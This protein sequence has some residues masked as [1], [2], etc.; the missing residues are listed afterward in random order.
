MS[1]RPAEEPHAVESGDDPPTAVSDQIPTPETVADT[2]AT[3]VTSDTS[4]HGQA[5]ASLSAPRDQ[6]AAT[7]AEPV[8][9]GSP[10]PH[11]PASEPAIFQPSES[12]STPEAE[13]PLEA[14]T[15]A[16]DAQVE[17]RRP[18]RPRPPQPS[19]TSPRPADTLFRDAPGD[20]SPSSWIARLAE[21]VR[22]A[23][24]TE[25]NR[26]GSAPVEPTPRPDGVREPSEPTS[27]PSETT[28]RFLAPR[29]GI[30]PA[31]VRVRRGAQ[32]SALASSHQADAVASGA[33]VVIAAGFPEDTPEGLGL[34]AH[35]LTHVARARQARFV[36]PITAQ[37]R[38]RPQTIQP[39]TIG[40]EE[41]MATTVEHLVRREA[42][43]IGAVAPFRQGR[44]VSD[45][46]DLTS[47]RNSESVAPLRHET[48]PT[49]QA[50]HGE[51]QD[52]W[53]GLP[54]PWEPMPS[55]LASPPGAA[56]TSRSNESR[57][58]SSGVRSAGE[59]RPVNI[60]ATMPV[61]SPVMA[62]ATNRSID[63]SSMSTSH[64]GASDQQQPAT[65]EPDLDA[66]ARQVYAVL[67]R[68]LAAERRRTG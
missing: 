25:A 67:K 6:T 1:S 26:R 34:L 23:Q 20:R 66:L 17:W 51:D 58:P 65:I 54:S 57:A 49:Q 63:A 47:D 36:P 45:S 35:E 21:T 59:P 62:A 41:S 43:Q 22:Q 13:Q 9:Q 15:S 14:G 11:V 28:R 7:L 31:D 16:P 18:S 5:E 8:S 42:Q 40:D 33:E 68:R 37:D 2:D 29:V 61:S 53:G 60:S 38:N 56:G 50:V 12:Q 46:G 48:G 39:T 32:A 27:P 24:N 19:A 52:E 3:I 64:D 30:D 44:A 55:W 10:Q 4:E